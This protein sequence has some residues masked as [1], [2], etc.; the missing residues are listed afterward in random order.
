MRTFP[1]RLQ[2]NTDVTE[3]EFLF[4]SRAEFILINLPNQRKERDIN[5]TGTNECAPERREDVNPDSGY[6][7]SPFS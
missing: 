1:K 2:A 6:G 7:V 4:H 5:A 3:A